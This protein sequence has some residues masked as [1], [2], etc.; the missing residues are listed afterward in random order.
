MLNKLIKYI[1]RYGDVLIVKNIILE[2]DSPVIKH[3]EHVDYVL[4]VTKIPIAIFVW[5]GEV[6]KMEIACAR[7]IR[8]EWYSYTETANDYYSQWGSYNNR[9][10]I[11]NE[12]DLKDIMDIIVNNFLSQDRNYNIKFKNLWVYSEMLYLIMEVDNVSKRNQ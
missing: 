10:C 9:V 12:D 11:L 6:I 4:F 8:G 2:P 7:R 5:T 1:S 3:S